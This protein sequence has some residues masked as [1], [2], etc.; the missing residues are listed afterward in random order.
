MTPALRHVVDGAVLVEYP[1]APD[2]EANRSAI[3]I[4]AAL[5]RR[6][7]PGLLD[8][9]PSARTL[10]LLFDPDLLDHSAAEELLLRI[11]PLQQGVEP[12]TVRLPAL[13]GGDAGPD[14]ADSD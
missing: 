8:A 6:P 4:A 11:E 7:P 10:L 9:I 3:A 1:G 2:A 13:Y 14:A 12:R 5:A